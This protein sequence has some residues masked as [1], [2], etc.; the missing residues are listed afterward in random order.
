MALI[1]EIMV[2]ISHV[3]CWKMYIQK[4]GKRKIICNLLILT[5][6]CFCLH[7]IW[8][9][10]K[11]LVIVVNLKPQLNVAWNGSKILSCRKLITCV[12][13]FLLRWNPDIF[14]LWIWT[15]ALLENVA[16]LAE[17]WVWDFETP[18]FWNQ[19]LFPLVVWIYFSN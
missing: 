18:G 7:L 14:K 6:F 3:Q 5:S 2:Q 9:K 10:K 15:C 17:K 12:S 19:L 4:Q 16:P 1:Y 11:Q 8:K 13:I